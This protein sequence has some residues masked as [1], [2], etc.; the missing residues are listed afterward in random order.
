MSNLP[1][2]LH[3]A[4]S[5][6]AVSR[7]FSRLL[8]ANFPK[9]Y[10]QRR[11]EEEEKLLAKRRNKAGD[12]E[13]SDNDEED[14]LLGTMVLCPVLPRQR[15]HLHIYEPRYRLMTQRCLEGSRRFGM[16]AR[17]S[18]GRTN[19]PASYGTEVEI[20]ECEPL[21]G[22]RYYMEVVGRR[23]FHVLDSWTTDDYLTCK[24]EWVDL[25]EGSSP[26]ASNGFSVRPI[27]PERT[28]ALSANLEQ[29][30]EM[31]QSLVYERGYE[32]NPDQLRRLYRDLGP[33]PPATSP[34]DRAMWVAALINPLPALGVAPE[35]RSN[36]LRAT[37]VLERVEVVTEGIRSSLLYM[38]P[39]LFRTIASR[40]MTHAQKL[41][42][43]LFRHSW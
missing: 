41:F 8:E 38:K 4:F 23:V 19:T 24:V 12:E 15:L 14:A 42:T 11:K 5:S 20:V 35:I 17:A 31:W 7:D 33:M 30:V 3:A 43:F 10:S 1:K 16:L 37:D 36:M 28:L 40:T 21:P 22:G 29:M 32:R 2:R 9:E 25:D 13:N 39:T 26:T 18:R 34:G 6:L 27:D